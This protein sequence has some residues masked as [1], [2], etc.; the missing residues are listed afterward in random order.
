[1]SGQ[2]RAAIRRYFENCK[3]KLFEEVDG[4]RRYFFEKRFEPIM[5]W[6]FG[7]HDEEIK[8]YGYGL[9]DDD[10]MRV[11]EERFQA[12]PSRYPP[13]VARSRS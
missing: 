3:V 12:L 1:M 2:C 5:V 8:V 6:Y 4:Y 9:F 13:V 11:H 7:E 10:D